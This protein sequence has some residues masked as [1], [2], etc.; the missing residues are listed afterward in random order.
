[1]S[2]TA[3]AT[4]THAWT[5]TIARLCEIDPAGCLFHV[6]SPNEN[7]RVRRYGG[8]REFVQRMV[9]TVRPGESFFDIGASVGLVSIH[10]RRRGARVTAFEP[11]PYIRERLIGNLQLNGMG[12]VHIADWAVSDAAG[13]ATLYTDGAHGASPSLATTVRRNA[14]QVRTQTIDAAIFGEA[15][16]LPDV[17]KIDVEGAEVRVIRG[18]SSTL[19]GPRR[20]RVLFIEI[21]PA[22]INA[23][24]DDQAE[25]SDILHARDYALVEQHTRD[26]QLHH[27]WHAR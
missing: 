24:G 22:F 26:D 8:E 18:M 20:P 9:E 3:T 10:A 5:P 15:L 14:V 12:D 17:V 4:A 25:L 11:D 2:A 27:T 13:N 6:G 23:F 19:A 21:H 7:F 16:P 1:M